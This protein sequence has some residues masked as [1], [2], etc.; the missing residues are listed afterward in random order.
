[1][2]L[3]KTDSDGVPLPVQEW[4]HNAF[5]RAVRF[6]T[7]AGESFEIDQEDLPPQAFNWSAQHEKRVCHDVDA[8]HLY[9]Y[10]NA[11]VEDHWQELHA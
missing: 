9:A 5:L 1:M 7:A 3:T 6:T 10:L 11:W 8:T 2:N 4:V